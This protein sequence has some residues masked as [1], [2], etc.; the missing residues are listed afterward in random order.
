M[1]PATIATLRDIKQGILERE[2]QA[3]KEIATRLDDLQT[4]RARIT[5]EIN[6]PLPQDTVA[7]TLTNQRYHLLQRKR[8]SELSETITTVTQQHDDAR[9]AL[10]LTFGET[11]AIE[12]L[13]KP[14]RR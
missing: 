14:P 6:N 1:K 13:Q 4:T 9:Q 12:R 10:S 2:T 8:L 7:N 3:L 11:R 5:D